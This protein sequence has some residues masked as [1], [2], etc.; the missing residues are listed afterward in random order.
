MV[1]TTLTTAL[2]MTSWRAPWPKVETSADGGVAIA[3]TP[4]RWVGNKQ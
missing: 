1:L 2:V 4:G 3:I